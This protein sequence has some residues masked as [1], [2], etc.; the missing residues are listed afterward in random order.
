MN[1]EFE[2]PYLQALHVLLRQHSRSL[3]QLLKDLSNRLEAL[4]L[5]T[6]RESEVQEEKVLYVETSRKEQYWLNYAQI[7]TVAVLPR[8]TSGGWVQESALSQGAEQMIVI[9]LTQ[10]W[11]NAITVS[12]HRKGSARIVDP[13]KIPSIG[14]SVAFDANKLATT[15]AKAIHRREIDSLS[16]S[17]KM[18]NV[19]SHTLE[20]RIE[21]GSLR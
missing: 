5:G 14:D 1:S 12:I 10:P 17:Y 20:I 4:E 19:E 21:M 15:I 9:C 18:G 13:E 3:Q 7:A 8:N 6:A 11:N 16:T 2:N